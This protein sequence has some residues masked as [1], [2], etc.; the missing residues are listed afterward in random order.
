MQSGRG[1]EAHAAGRRL[2]TKAMGGPHGG[3]HVV[4]RCAGLP[5]G[6]EKKV[7]NSAIGE[8]RFAVERRPKA[9][10]AGL[11]RA[12]GDPEESGKTKGLAETKQRAACVKRSRPPDQPTID[13][14]GRPSKVGGCEGGGDLVEAG[15]PSPSLPPTE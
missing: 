3:K 13:A 2:V 14:G 6:I 4:E 8:E 5:I 11:A 1:Q 10:T 7:V 9:V 12:F 15:F